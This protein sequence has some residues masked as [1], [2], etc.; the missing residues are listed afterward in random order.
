V[1]HGDRVCVPSP[2]PSNHPFG[3]RPSA[4]YAIAAVSVALAFPVRWSLGLSFGERP[5]LVLFV[6]PIPIL[7]SA[8]VGGLGPGLMATVLAAAGT[9][10][11]LVPPARS[12]RIERGVD[13]FQWLVLCTWR[14][15]SSPP[16]WSRW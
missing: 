6:I 12:F 13:A 15:R 16:S 14:S 9:E 8:Y 11:L 10:Y 1:A 2:S 4:G 3:R 7:L 5:L